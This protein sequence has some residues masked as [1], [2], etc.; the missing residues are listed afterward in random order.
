MDWEDGEEPS[1]CLG[2]PNAV[3]RFDEA[4]AL[5]GKYTRVRS[6]RARY[7]NIETGYLLRRVEWHG[8][9]VI[10]TTNLRRHMDSAFSR[11]GSSPRFLPSRARICASRSGIGAPPAPHASLL[12][13][14][15]REPRGWPT[16]GWPRRKED[17]RLTTVRQ[18]ATAA[19]AIV[20]GLVA[21]LVTPV[22]W[23]GLCAALFADWLKELPSG[24]TTPVSYA[25]LLAPLGVVFLCIARGRADPEDWA[26]ESKAFVGAL[27]LAWILFV[28][29]RLWIMH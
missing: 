26:P 17:F 18:V 6:A 25:I 3:P 29:G 20:L 5:L 21:G 15:N 11:N 14:V 10:L 7:A 22:L 27:F 16:R 2:E 13:S 1:A 9:I 28:F 24:L 12:R 19:W 4:D 23:L 8:G